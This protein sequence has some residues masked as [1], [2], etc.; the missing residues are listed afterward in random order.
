MV[1]SWTEYVQLWCIIRFFDIQ[2]S[3]YVENL[4][5]CKTKSSTTIQLKLLSLQEQNSIRQ[6]EF[7]VV[8]G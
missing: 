1:I 6:L 3:Q 5:S 4:I 2:I 7:Y 8:S